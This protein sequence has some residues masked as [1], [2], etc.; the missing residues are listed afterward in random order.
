[1]A[2]S[3][4]TA[5]VEGR[6]SNEAGLKVTCLWILKKD[7]T[8]KDLYAVTYLKLLILVCVSRLDGLKPK[9]LS[10]TRSEEHG[11]LFEVSSQNSSTCETSICGIYGGFL[12]RKVKQK[13]AA[14]KCSC[15]CNKDAK[16]TFYRNNS[17]QQACVKDADVVRDGNRGTET[18]KC[19]YFFF[20]STTLVLYRK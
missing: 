3:T 4:E 19:T 13:T 20:C 5:R 8:R 17:G 1:M 15:Y 11:D 7:M 2:T 10:V 16:P 6:N 9:L 12:H 14:N 18:I